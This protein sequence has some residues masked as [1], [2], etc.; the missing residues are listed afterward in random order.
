MGMRVETVDVNRIRQN[1]KEGVDNMKEKMKGWGEEVKESAQNV[2]S[3]AKEVSSTR[4]KA[5]AAEVNETVRRSS[6]GIGHAIGVLFKVFFLFI[7]GTIAFALFVSLIAL[8]FG[9][10]QWWPVNNF[11]WTSNWRQL[12]AWVL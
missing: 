5:F 7:A 6:G 3:K 9:G 8:L 2:S 10:V 11:L 12:Y 1:V 4:G